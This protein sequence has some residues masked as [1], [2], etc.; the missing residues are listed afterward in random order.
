MRRRYRKPI[1]KSSRFV[2]SD[3]DCLHFQYNRE[4]LMELMASRL[5]RLAVDMGRVLAMGILE[6]EVS[7]LC[8]E[9]NQHLPDR[10]MTRYGYDPGWIAMAGQKLT[11]D[12]PRVRST[13][14]KGEIRLSRYARMQAR[15][16]MPQAVLKR[17]VHG[18]SC[19]NYEGVVDCAQ[20]G[21]GLKKSSV[22]RAL[23][24]ALADEVRKLSNRRWDGVRLVAIY[25][26]ATPYAGESMVAAM[27]IT[28]RGDKHILGLRQG[29]TENAEVCK[30][31]LEDLCERG[32][33]PDVM[34]LFILDGSKALRA[35]VDR[36]WGKYAVIQ[37]C[38]QHKRRN[39]R[40]YLNETYWSELDRRLA[41]AY[42][43]TD[44]DPA[45]V[46]LRQTLKW[47]N[48]INPDAARSLEDGLVETLTVVRLKVP[49]ILRKTLASTNPMESV[50]GTVEQ[51]TGRVTNWQQ[52]AMRRRWCAGGLLHAEQHFNRVKGYRH[53]P[54]LVTTL[55][56]MA[57]DKGLDAKAV[58]A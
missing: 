29:A 27:G 17:M 43:E 13:R 34:T 57:H 6:D 30:D 49:A 50:F 54:Q 2:R 38:Q 40:Q 21:F 4:E 20:K 52:G 44:Y 7:Q 25:I 22:G 16:R 58:V 41:E 12:R 53:L 47:L 8:G 36:V 46:Q 5:D 1:A 26:D 23:K 9:P 18:V 35:A 33:A 15:E 39:I 51:T 24:R 14:G 45:L 3:K 42:Q 10:T 37:R 31:L 55:D 11:V 56:A 28:V 32:V 19:R 48:G